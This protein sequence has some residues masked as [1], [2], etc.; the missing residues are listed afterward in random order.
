MEQEENL[1]APIIPLH[2][3]EVG[4]PLKISSKLYVVRYLEDK[5]AS[6]NDYK[7]CKNKNYES[8]VFIKSGVFYETYDNDC[9]IMVDLFEYKIKNFKNFSRTVFP[10]NN[11]DK[12]KEK[13]TEKQINYIIVE[14]NNIS[15]IT[16]ENNRYNFYVNKKVN[17]RLYKNHYQANF[18]EQ[19]ELINEYK[20][21]MKYIEKTIEAFPK[22]EKVL[23]DR[24][25]NN[26]YE[27]LELIYMSNIIS[28]RTTYQS[29]I[30]AKLKMLDF[31]LSQSLE[32]NYIN[33]KKY[34]KCG[35]FLIKIVNLTEAWMISTYEKSK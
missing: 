14:N 19:L 30:I 26:L 34:N 35:N 4:K 15:K 25:I 31:Y 1:L 7:E 3:S 8:L 29:K 32:K 27:I 24:T 9:K 10:I 11:I 12:V 6:Y 20:K 16:F 28:D 18:N 17:K 33:Y 22:S 21:T 23:K 5:M 2:L 13:L